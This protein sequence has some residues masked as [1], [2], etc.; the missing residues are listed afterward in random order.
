MESPLRI[1]LR[2]V[3]QEWWQLLSCAG[4]TIVGFY[5][6]ANNKDNR[7]LVMAMGLLAAFFLVWATYKAWLKTYTALQEQLEKNVKPDLAV[8]IR[9]LRLF[10]DLEYPEPG[11][12]KVVGTDFEFTVEIV[13]KSFAETNVTRVT[14]EV[15]DGTRKKYECEAWVYKLPTSTSPS[16][17]LYGPP[18][19]PH[20]RETILTR[21]ITHS[22][23]GSGGFRGLMP[24]TMAKDSLR[25]FAFDCNGQYAANIVGT[26][27]VTV[28]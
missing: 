19:A 21:M 2:A 8:T 10:P 24:E 20:V 27:D 25:I 16:A 15:R 4:F 5:A 26:I 28:I 22:F 11:K 7:W 3:R 6:A 1:Y 14:V 17:E 9:A 18:V 23:Y 13:N 12:P